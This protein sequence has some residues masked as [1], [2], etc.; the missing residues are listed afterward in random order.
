MID[1]I[2][3]LFSDV[4]EGTL[5]KEKVVK[6][7]D[8]CINNIRNDVIPG[9]E[10]VVS[11]KNLSNIKESKP[12]LNLGRDAK[13]K[14]SNP[15]DI[16][17]SLLSFFKRVDDN[18]DKMMDV[19]NKYFST[20]ITSKTLTARDGAILRIVSDITSMGL[21]V[22]DYVY[23]AIMGKD[24]TGYPPAHIKE[25][26]GGYPAFVSLLLEYNK[27][28]EKFIDN[29]KNVSTEAIPTDGDKVMLN[30]MMSRTGKLL[31]LPTTKGFIGNPFYHI[32]MLYVDFEHSRYK[33][34]IEKKRLLE[35]K[36]LALEADKDKQG[37]DVNKLN[38]QIEYYEELI[39]DLEYKIKKYEDKAL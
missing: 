35:L 30:T 10:S 27:S 12:L 16:V 15:G 13:L 36:L 8:F 32:R 34:N 23:I 18:G 33:A 11:A 1:A 19:V 22:L 4:E 29:V 3:H 7:L 26:E 38:K 2:K 31:D 9:L 14:D 21:Y 28:L 6:N 20:A 39:T 17:T 25:V 24:K 37:A 5:T